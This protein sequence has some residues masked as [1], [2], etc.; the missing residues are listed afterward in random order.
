MVVEIGIT[1]TKNQGKK[2]KKA[3]TLLLLSCE[4]N[5]STT[6]VSNRSK[7]LITRSNRDRDT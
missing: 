4:N 6:A 3:A 1:R 5:P 2:L 7:N